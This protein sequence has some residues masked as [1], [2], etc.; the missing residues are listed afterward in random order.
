MEAHP[1]KLYHARA[2]FHEINIEQKYYYEIIG[3]L[4]R[5]QRQKRFSV[6]SK[7]LFPITHFS[8]LFVIV[9]FSFCSSCCI[10]W[11]CGLKLIFL[12]V[13]QYMGTERLLATWPENIWCQNEDWLG[14]L[15]WWFC[16]HM[17][18]CWKWLSSPC[19]FSRNFGGSIW[20][21]FLFFILMY[22]CLCLKLLYKLLNL[23]VIIFCCSA[24]ISLFGFI[25]FFILYVRVM[26]MPFLSLSHVGSNWSAYD[27]LQKGV[28]CNGWLFNQLF[29]GLPH[30]HNLIV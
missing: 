2:L 26:L 13:S 21:C 1:Y 5:N 23:K 6:R 17:F 14:A 3:S 29:W 30:K 19:S 18:V 11:I 7:I 27:R 10:S 16:F 20:R 12:A 9:P 24:N 22:L 28:C 15:D 8:L 4:T 25:Q